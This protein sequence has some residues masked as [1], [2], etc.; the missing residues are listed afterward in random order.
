MGTHILQCEHSHTFELCVVQIQERSEYVNTL[1]TRPWRP[2]FTGKPV[3]FK[4]NI[5]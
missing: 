4:T 3:D 2:N 5:W 1:P